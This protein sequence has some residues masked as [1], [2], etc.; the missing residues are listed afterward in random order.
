ML[1]IITDSAADV[2]KKEAEEYGI[3]IM[4]IPI[5]VDGVTYRESVDF[6]SEEYYPMLL[7]RRPSPPPPRSP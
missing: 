5:T 7:G 6:T 1:K 3:R 4:P 2:P